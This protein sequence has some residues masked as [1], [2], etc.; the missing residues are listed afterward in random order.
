MRGSPEKIII[1]KEP[2]PEEKG[3]KK[4][5][6]RELTPGEDSYINKFIGEQE[7]PDYSKR[8]GITPETHRKKFV[9]ILE[10]YDIFIT[11]DEMCSRGNFEIK[12]ELG[13]RVRELLEK[14]AEGNTL[15]ELREVLYREGREDEKDKED[16]K[17][18]KKYLAYLVQKNIK[19]YEIRDFL[20]YKFPLRDVTKR[21][22]NSAI[23]R[24]LETIR[25]EK[26][27]KGTPFSYGKSEQ[28]TEKIK[29]KTIRDGEKDLKLVNLT[30][31]E[32]S[33]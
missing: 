8:A 31:R 23:L 25:K 13:N 16:K 21:L 20:K 30:K 7:Y 12:K 27:K 28:I 22:A 5:E 24:E 11:S 4:I 14:N 15:D 10:S 6:A 3:L 33:K 1:K 2:K 26:E 32:S 29:E 18:E 17:D 19:K 9:E